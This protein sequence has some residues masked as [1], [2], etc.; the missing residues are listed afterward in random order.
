MGEDGKCS[1]PNC[2]MHGEKMTRTMHKDGECKCE[3]K[4]C[5]CENCKEHGKK[6]ACTMD[7]DGKCTNPEC[8]EH[9]KI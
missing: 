8:A 6:M 7:K 5:S 2:E 9:S 4:K 3:G 1:N